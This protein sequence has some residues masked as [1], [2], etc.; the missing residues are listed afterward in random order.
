MITLFA[1]HED[2][3]QIQV[4]EKGVEMRPLHCRG[5]G[6]P[7]WNL[8]AGEYA[9]IDRISQGTPP[10]Y[11]RCKVRSLHQLHLVVSVSC[12]QYVELIRP[13]PT[14]RSNVIQMTAKCHTNARKM[15]HK[16]KKNLTRAAQRHNGARRALYGGGRSGPDRAERPKPRLQASGRCQTNHESGVH[17]SIC[18]ARREKRFFGTVEWTVCELID[19][20][21]S[22]S[23]N[24]PTALSAKTMRFFADVRMENRLR[25]QCYSR[26]RSWPDYRCLCDIGAGSLPRET[27]CR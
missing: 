19:R 18:V 20:K 13:K 1:M 3:A 10:S 16:C 4:Y 6:R 9:G 21:L 15:S 22:M 17:T 12:T 2:E 23:V 24:S 25:V 26:W 5:V 27:R 14:V 8:I 7:A 11:G